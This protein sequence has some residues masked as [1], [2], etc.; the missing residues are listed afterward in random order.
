MEFIGAFES[1]YLP[2]YD[3]DVME[4]SGHSWRRRDDLALLAGCGVQTLRYPVRWHRVEAAPGRFDWRA[5][6]RLM[7]DLRRAGLRPIVDL[8]HHTSYP[9]WLSGGFA[10]PRFGPAFVRFCD[11]FGA[12]YPWVLEYTV[13][14]EPFATLFLAGHE[15]IWP[16]YGR[17]LR[18]F[19]ALMRNVLPAVSTATWRLRERLPDAL[20]VYVDTCEG[21]TALDASGEETA[22]LNNDRRFFLLDRLLGRP[23]DGPFARAVA[24]AGGADLLELAPAPVDVLGLDYYAHSEWAFG[25][26]GPVCPSPR[27]AGLAALIGE[28]N[29]RYPELPLILSETNLRGTTADRATWLRHTLEQCERAEAAGAPLGGY[30][31]FPLIDSVDW[32]SLLA[33]A[34]GCIDPVGVFWLDA[35]ARRH[36]SSMSRA[37]AEAAAGT[38]SAGLPAYRFSRHAAGHLAGLLD[39]ME[40]F[41]WQDPPAEEAGLVDLDTVTRLRRRGVAA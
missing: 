39:R 31:W 27:P 40:H 33:R 9:R 4:L 5:T 10:D 30:C 3:V 6:D 41:D 34:D 8:L 26:G 14:N 23:A 38:P 1:T 21:H 12:R 22:A 37:Y 20:H 13:M 24:A 35:D 7:A 17:G 29:A 16:P 11:A 28:Y 18:G 25:A 32:N 19:A 36:A 15:A 2:G